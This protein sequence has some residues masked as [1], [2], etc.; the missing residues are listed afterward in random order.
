VRILTELDAVIRLALTITQPLE[1]LVLTV[2]PLEDIVKALG[3]PVT[4]LLE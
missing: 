1:P 3:V 4:E 2:I